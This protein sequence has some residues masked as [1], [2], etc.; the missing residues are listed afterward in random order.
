[1]T[2]DQFINQL[3][4][5]AIDQELAD[6]AAT[7]PISALRASEL[8]RAFTKVVRWHTQFDF[9][10]DVRPGEMPVEN[11][12]DEDGDSMWTTSSF[13]LKNSHYLRILIPEGMSKEVAMRGLRK[14]AD[15]IEK[16]YEPQTRGGAI[17]FRLGNEL[18]R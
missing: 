8:K 16:S 1:M 14:L 13:D 2:R 12:T 5:P 18:L 7:T 3:D 4:E 6:W 17:S 11:C 9:F 15:W 10:P